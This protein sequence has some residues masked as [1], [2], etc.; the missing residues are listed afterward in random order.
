VTEQE[1][2]DDLPPRSRRAYLALRDRIR[3]GKIEAGAKLPPF[4]SLAGQLGISPVTMRKVLLALQH[5]GWVSVEQGRGT[6]VQAV[7]RPGV[8]V[9]EDDPVQ[10][11]LLRQQVEMAG[12]RTLEASSPTE[13]LAALKSEARFGL[14]ISDVRMPDKASG[15]EFIRTV[16]HRWP[17]VP[18]AAVTAH[19]EDL[20]ELHGTPDCPVLVLAKPVSRRQIEEAISLVFHAPVPN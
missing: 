9:V 17:N 18:L 5:A 4:D 8:L 6:F 13:G 10:R 3:T 20:S 12:Y 1:I 7:E 19:P 15:V 14:I 16:R 11:Q 2:L